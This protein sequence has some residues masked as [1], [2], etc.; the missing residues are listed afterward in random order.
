MQRR[1]LTAGRRS[2]SFLRSR[3][4]KPLGQ[5]EAAERARAAGPC[6]DRLLDD[7]IA[8]LSVLLSSPSLSHVLLSCRPLRVPDG[9]RALCD[10]L[11]G[12]RRLFPLLQTR[13]DWRNSAG[14]TDA[15][16]VNAA[17]WLGP[18]CVS[19]P[20]TVRCTGALAL[21]LPLPLASATLL[22]ATERCRTKQR[23]TQQLQCSSVQQ[24]F[25]CFSL[26]L[27]AGLVRYLCPF[28]SE[29]REGERLRPARA[30]GREG[31]RRMGAIKQSQPN[32]Y[33]GA[34]ICLLRANDMANHF[35][36]LSWQ[37]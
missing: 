21:P 20:T 16:Q 6:V 27:L 1:Q 18:Q 33:D 10:G 30:R 32:Q 8:V 12:L 34:S 14:A 35:T 24:W 9:W 28:R 25:D 29:A 2:P 22:E 4:V 31:L 11:A 36:I 3:F 5:C 23:G 15:L 26:L 17:G 37:R 13:E 7:D 19:G